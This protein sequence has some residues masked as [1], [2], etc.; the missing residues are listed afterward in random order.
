MNREVKTNEREIV[1]LP[2][3][4]KVENARIVVEL[5]KR[6][7]SLMPVGI[8]FY[9][10]ESLPDCSRRPKKALR[11]CEAVNSVMRTSNSLL[12]TEEDLS[13][14]VAREILGFNRNSRFIISECVEE[15]LRKNRF[16]DEESAFKALEVIPRM[17]RAPKSILLSIDMPSPDVYVLYL[18]P[19]GFMKLVQAYHKATGKEMSL[20]VS[21]VMPV[22]GNCTI[23]PFVTDRTCISFGC[24]D[25]R[26]YG[27]LSDDKLAVGMPFHEAV[28]VVQSLEHI[29]GRR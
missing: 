20:N 29:E 14:P 25:C 11:Y 18:Q 5:F 8:R 23:R 4:E 21:S 7:L 22:C 16:N 3:R 24:P 19:V 10:G 15:L 28:L 13:C 1:R 17:E 27:G 2:R 6:H 26:E 9:F 12:L